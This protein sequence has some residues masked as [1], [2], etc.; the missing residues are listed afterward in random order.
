MDTFFYKTSP[1]GVIR[2]IGEDAEDY[3]QS[4]WS[5]NL[6]KLPHGGIRYGLRLST[7]GKVLADSYILRLGD[8]EFLLLSKD[9]EG[10]HIISL[11]NENIV[12]DEVEFINETQN[13]EIISFWNEGKNSDLHIENIAKPEKNQFTTME[14]GFYFEDF[15]AFPGA[16]IILLSIQSKWKMD[17]DLISKKKNVFEELRI[18]AGEVSIPCEIGSDDLP[19]EGKLEKIAVDFDKG[20]YLGQE[21]MA[22]IH[23]MGRVRRQA[24]PVSWASTKIP[25]IPCPLFAGEKKVGVL[26][27]MIQTENGNSIGMA[28]IHEKGL[29]TLNSE[30]LQIEGFTD[31]KLRKV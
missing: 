16:F 8:E 23:A 21:V 17:A 6:R 15:R 3:L 10:D 20:C 7:K 27:S 9:C 26:K 1:K 22:R 19:Q 31:L 11:L 12:A 25:T 4:Q 13:W 28:L 5:I 2:I 29:D 14:D 30:G 24:R 18:R